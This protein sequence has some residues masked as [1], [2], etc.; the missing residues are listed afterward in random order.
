MP[1]RRH[2]SGCEYPGSAR[3]QLIVDDDA[4]G[5]RETGSGGELHAGRR[6]DPD[7][8]EICLERGA[9]AE[10]DGLDGMPTTEADDLSAGEDLHTVLE[11]KVSD[12]GSDFRPKGSF[13]GDG[14]R[15]DHGHSRA[16]LPDRRRHL[17]ADPAAADDDD[18]ARARDRFSD[19][20]GVRAGPEEVNA[21][22]VLARHVEDARG[23]ARR[24]QQPVERESLP[25]RELTIGSRGSIAVT[26]VS[27]ARSIL[28]SSYHDAGW[29]MAFSNGDSP[30]R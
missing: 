1:R 11:M 7:D 5:H 28:C 26:R 20:V 17:G 29:T 16:A 2:I 19:G 3:G 4:V 6:A 22:E 10:V 21:L 30:R 23:G 24:K 13:E 9:V 12:D 25:V 8:D 15:R 27:R 18:M 14:V